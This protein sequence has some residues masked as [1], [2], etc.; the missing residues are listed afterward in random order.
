MP[1]ADKIRGEASG[2]LLKAR[3][4][5]GPRL[6]FGAIDGIGML[7]VPRTTYDVQDVSLAQAK[8]TSFVLLEVDCSSNVNVVEWCLWCPQLIA[9]YMMAV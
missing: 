7:D 8:S 2:C 1:T 5:K 6:Q 3:E 4:G 9:R